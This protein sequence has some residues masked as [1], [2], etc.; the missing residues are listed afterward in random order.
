MTEPY[1]PVIA[2]PCPHCGSGRT[3]RTKRKTFLQILVLHR[4]G[5]FPW[6]CNYCRKDFMYKNRGRLR[7]SHQANGQIG[8][9][10]AG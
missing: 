2:P 3:A 6:E 1:S 9:P 7:R 4:F 8:L 10:H 5:L